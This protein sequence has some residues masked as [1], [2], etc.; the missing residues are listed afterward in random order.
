MLRD[1]CGHCGRGIPLLVGPLAIGRSP[2]C[3]GD[4]R[5]CVAEPISSSKYS[6]AQV[7]VEIP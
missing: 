5:Q 6:I 4:L 2:A 7:H 1:R 3:G